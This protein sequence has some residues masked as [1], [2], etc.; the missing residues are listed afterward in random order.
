MAWR[1]A[2]MV[3]W[4]EIPVASTAFVALMRRLGW[5]ISMGHLE[6]L[7]LWGGG[8]CCVHSVCIVY[9]VLG[10][11]VLWLSQHLRHSGWSFFVAFSAFVV[12]MRHWGGTPVAFTMFLLLTECLGWSLVKFTAFVVFMR[13]SSWLCLWRLECL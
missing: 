12:F 7:G 11:D 4:G 8:P 2:F 10:L 3:H 6:C 13:R 9:E 5:F 1:V